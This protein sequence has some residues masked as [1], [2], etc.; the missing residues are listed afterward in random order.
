VSGSAALATDGAS[1]YAPSMA[2]RPSPQVANGALTLEPLTA[3]QREVLDAWERSG[4]PETP[5]V[6]ALRKR[7]RG[8]SLSPTERALLDGPGR[9]PAA[10]GVPHTQVLE[11]LEERR[12]RGA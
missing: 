1:T 2:T 10:Q 7:A 8:E 6:A 3:E 5:Q 12:R 4:R 11:Q 9:K